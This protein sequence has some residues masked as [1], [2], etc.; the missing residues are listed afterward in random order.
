MNDRKP[1]LYEI[2][3]VPPAA[4]LPQIR[5]AYQALQDQIATGKSGL[6]PEAAAIKQNWIALA[7]STL[8]DPVSRSTYDRKLAQQSQREAVAQVTSSIAAAPVP[9]PPSAPVRPAPDL[10]AILAAQAGPVSSAITGSASSLRKI[11]FFIAVLLAASFVIQL[12]FSYSA[13]RR[14]HEVANNAATAEDRVVIQEYYQEHGVR[15]ASRAE[16][17]LLREE[18]RRKEAEQRKAEHAQEK[19]EREYQRFVD[20]ARRKS[21]EVS[22]GLERAAEQARYEDEQKRRKAEQEERDRQYQ[23]RVRLENERR[24]LGIGY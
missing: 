15:P 16:A 14:L 24:R 3:G 5:D 13:N 17:D 2:L 9:P 1:T 4:S 12:S 21:E 18:E 11:L 10:E 23:E 8:S 6:D 20:D 19:Q 7:W 22:A